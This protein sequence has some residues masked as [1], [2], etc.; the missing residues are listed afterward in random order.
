MA[1]LAVAQT[2][3]GGVLVQACIELIRRIAGSIFVDAHAARF[4][5]LDT[6]RARGLHPIG[7]IAGKHCVR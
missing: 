3:H 5:H 7:A 6:L 1:T 2:A 4:V